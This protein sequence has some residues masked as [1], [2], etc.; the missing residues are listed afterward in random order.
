MGIPNWMSICFIVV[1]RSQPSIE[2]VIK[3]QIHYG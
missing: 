3:A 1:D 2:G